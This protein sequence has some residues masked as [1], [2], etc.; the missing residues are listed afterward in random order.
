MAKT[1]THACFID[2]DGGII[3]V[4]CFECGSEITRVPLRS[5]ASR[6]QGV[7]EMLTGVEP[8]CKTCD[9]ARRNK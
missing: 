9:K 8:I 7:A 2:K 5:P 1:K 6:H 3:S 4:V